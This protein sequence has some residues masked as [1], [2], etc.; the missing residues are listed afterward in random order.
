MPPNTQARC[1]QCGHE[2][3]PRGPSRRPSRCPACGVRFSYAVDRTGSGCGGIGS[4]LLAGVIG[5]AALVAAPICLCGGLVNLFDGR[6]Q[7][8]DQKSKDAAPPAPTAGNP[9]RPGQPTP[10][11]QSAAPQPA[12]VAPPPR[13]VVRP[14][15]PYPRPIHPLRPPDG[16]ASAWQE[17]GQVRGRI[18]GVAFAPAPIAIGV[19]YGRTPERHLLIWFEFENRGPATRVFRRYNP[20][21]EFAVTDADGVPFVG[22]SLPPGARIG[23]PLPAL[24][25]IPVFGESVI[26]LV[27]LGAPEPPALP[28]T[29]RIDA[30]RVG[31]RGRFT[32]VIPPAAWRQDPR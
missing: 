24:Q 5:L 4:T 31:E 21:D 23:D 20:G 32:F 19:T 30:V 14:L 22:A 1:S 26:G 27:A 15:A 16:W 12:V 29:V 10:H 9:D 8:E 3:Y 7:H 2:W 25:D 18:R 6:G 11:L 13:L 28:L 17:V